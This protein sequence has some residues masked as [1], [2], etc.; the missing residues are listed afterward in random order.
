MTRISL[1]SRFKTWRDSFAMPG[2]SRDE[3]SDLNK[4]IDTALKVALG[5]PR[6]H[7][8]IGMDNECPEF[9]WCRQGKRG[10]H[11]VGTIRVELEGEA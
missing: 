7:R 11:P 10:Y 5:C 3:V 4:L 6:C 9:Y 2:N 8:F 1:R